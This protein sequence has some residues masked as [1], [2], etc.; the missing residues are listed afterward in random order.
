MAFITQWRVLSVLGALISPC[1]FA[2]Y[3]FELDDVK[4]EA[5]LA[6]GAASI[7]AS[8][9]N[10]GAGRVDLRNGRN[11]GER[12]D[13]QEMYLKPGVTLSYALS[14][15]LEVFAGAS[16]VGATTFG[17]GDAGGYTRS[18]DG[19]VSVE[20]SY[21]GVREGDWSLS[22]GRQDYKVGTGFIVM[23]GN[24]DFF[25]DGAY[26]I[27]PRTAFRDSAILG[28]KHDRLSAQAFSLRTDDDLGDFR[29]N[30]VN[31]D[32]DLAGAVTLGAMAMK[33]NSLDLAANTLTPREGM[34]VYNLRALQGKVPGLVDLTLH[35]EYA[36]ERGSGAGVDY[37]ASAWYA[38]G[39]YAF[40]S[41]PLQ[42]LLSYRYAA[43]SGDD[44]PTDTKKKSW[45]PLNKGYVDWGT[46][47]IGD[48][49]G[50]Y[51]LFNSNERVSQW[52]L[53]T[54]LTPTVNL[55]GIH[56]QFNLDEKVL[57]GA[58]VNDRRFADENVVFLEWTPT[59]SLYTTLS[60][61]WVKPLAAARES[62]GNDDFSAL[63]MFVSYRY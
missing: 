55:G 23:D 7:R 17:D 60:Y 2:G 53:R 30:G 59:A 44:D 61:N 28:Y 63:E 38:Q 18:S 45:D 9:V 12:A 33:V 13:W 62:Y 4:G 56:Y 25:D 42:P 46:W 29:M 51:L 6:A 35:G 50:N 15:G 27:G 1:A 40:P 41:L 54:H 39:D 11:T 16:A 32:Y 22:A 3:A 52:T 43:F 49:V 37:D 57:N 10:F 20:A 48:V 5:T 26:W 47:L 36:V 19:G 21:V 14:S 31:I 34:Q 58:P 24:L 8:N